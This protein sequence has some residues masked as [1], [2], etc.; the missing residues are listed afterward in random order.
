MQITFYHQTTPLN[1]LSRNLTQ[2][3][4]MTGTLKEGCDILN[5]DIRV[6]FNS[7]FITNANY[8]YIPDFGRYYYFREPPTIEGDFMIIH[9][10]AD[11]L[12]NYKELV[13]ASDCI[14][15][16][17]SNR[18]NLKLKDSALLGE[19]GYNYYSRSLEGGYSFQPD[20]GKYILCTGGK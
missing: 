11:A 15:E 19:T 4:S 1:N 8:A 9:L 20:A 17:S 6:N 3:A 13:L 16:R 2:S 18:Y 7:G 12:Y 14:A 10:H 5:P